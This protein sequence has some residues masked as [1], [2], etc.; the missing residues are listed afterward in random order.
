[1][2]KLY[3]ETAKKYQNEAGTQTDAINQSRGKEL[4]QMQAAIYEQEQLLQQNIQ[5]SVQ[6]AQYE[7]MLPVRNKMM[8]AINKVANTLGYDYVLDVASLVVANGPDITAEV[9]KELGM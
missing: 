2:V 1:M 6:K 8:E 4:Q 3:E 5:T 9:K 7:A